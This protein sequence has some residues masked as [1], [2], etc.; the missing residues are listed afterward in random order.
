MKEKFLIILL[1]IAPIFL[2]NSCKKDPL[3]ENQSKISVLID[4]DVGIDDAIAILYLL[5]HPELNVGGITIAGTGMSNLEPATINALGLIELAGK[6]NIPVTKGDTVAV[7]S[8]NT[9]LRPPEWLAESNTMM[10]LNLPINPNP[11]LNKSAVDFMVE[12]L[13][14]AEKPVRIVVLG[15]LT[16]LGMVLQQNPGLAAKIESVYI[17]GGAVNVPGNLQYGGVD[18]NPF[19]EWN[20]FL[21]PEAAQIVFQS[22]INIVLVPLDATNKAP[23]PAEFYKR[24]TNDHTT[25]E[26]DF[27]YEMMSKLMEVYDT[28]YFWDPLAAAISSDQ[29]ITNT[30]THLITIIT[31]E[32]N[33]NGRT[34]IDS[35]AGNIVNVCYD[36]DMNNFENLFLDV[37]NGR[38]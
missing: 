5:Q 29:N 16:N 37:L 22:G 2:F 32:G 1:A 18:D 12:I 3:P 11:A 17:M 10:G 4:T 25:P 19:A 8:Q 14:D 33:E 34:K 36:T 15:P 6:P 13:G 21:D 30:N 24:F 7:N 26:A 27:V 38:K 35:V 31:E 23:V 9:L 20:I 28:F